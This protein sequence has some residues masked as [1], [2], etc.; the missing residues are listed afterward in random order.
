GNT[1]G[2]R[3]F[4]GYDP[5]MRVGVVVLSNAGT[6]AGI[7]DIGIHLLNPKVPLLAA[8]ALQPQRER[9]QI[10]LGSQV[11]GK[12]VGRYEFP[13]HQMAS[14]TMDGDHLLLQGEGEVKIAFYPETPRDFFA[15]IMDAQITFET[16]ERGNVTGLLFHRSGSVQQV[17]RAR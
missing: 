9:Q 2:Y 11:L 12:Y 4:I 16:D 14:I 3:S 10:T 13:S 1:G 8:E 5:K 7:E 6:G 17:K 15:T